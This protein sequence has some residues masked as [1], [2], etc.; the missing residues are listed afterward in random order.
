M[1]SHLYLRGPLLGEVKTCRLSSSIID[2]LPEATESLGIAY[3]FFDGRDSQNELQLHNKLIRALI[4]QLSDTRHGGITEILAD[5]YKRCGE[6]QQPSDEQLQNVLRSILDRFSQAYIMIDAL[7]ECTDRKKTMN[8]ANKLISDTKS[9]TANLHLLV[10][11]RPER[12]IHENFAALDHSIDVGE[13]NSND[14]VEYLK[15]Q[16]SKF[17]KYDEDTRLKIKSVLEE[18]AEGS[19]VKLLF[20]NLT[21][22]F[23]LAYPFFMRFRWVALQLT[24]LE[25]CLSRYE[26]DK[27]LAE[28][29]EG[30]DE[31]Y[32]RILKN[33]DKKY[34]ADTR[35]FLQWLAFCMRPMTIKEIAETITADFPSGKCPIFNQ[36]KRYADPRDVLVRCSSFVT[37][38]EGKYRWLN[39]AFSL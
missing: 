19:Y 38:S 23:T 17:S 35:M 16:M 9:E 7:D 18:R 30:L 26:I 2:K 25:K 31:T 3:F 37:E 39:P 22:C 28:L 27:Q 6:V 11:S 15:L 32:N 13:A 8:W 21:V 5:L 4:S 1:V 33:I 24:E 12:D 29:P 10:T 36:D 20:F 14:I 34:Y